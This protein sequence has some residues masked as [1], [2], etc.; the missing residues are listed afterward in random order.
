MPIPPIFF[1]F[2]HRDTLIGGSRGGHKK[3]GPFFQVGGKW[4]EKFLPVSTPYGSLGLSTSSSSLR[5]D[6]GNLSLCLI[7]FLR[8][9]KNDVENL[10]STVNRKDLTKGTKSFFSVYLKKFFLSPNGGF[11]RACTITHYHSAESLYHYHLVVIRQV[12]KKI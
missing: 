5:T 4:Q 11:C 8:R 7:L 3:V 12:Q 2:L 10:S 6:N 1:L 9:E